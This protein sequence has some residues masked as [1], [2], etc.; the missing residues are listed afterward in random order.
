M[1]CESGEG[2]AYAPAA[3][4]GGKARFAKEEDVIILCK[5]NA[6]SFSMS[7]LSDPL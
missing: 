7:A 4:V 3:G 6:R 5:L 2:L 1:T